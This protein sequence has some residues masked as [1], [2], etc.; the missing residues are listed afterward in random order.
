[1]GIQDKVLFDASDIA[2]QRCSF[3][4]AVIKIN[5]NLDFLSGALKPY[6]DT[7]AMVSGICETAKNQKDNYDI[8]LIDC[9]SGI[10]FTVKSLA[11]ISNASIVITTPDITAIRD[12]GRAASLIYGEKTDD[13]RL[14]VNKVKP[15]FIQKGLAPDI[16]EIIDN[17]EVRL[18][19]LIPE[20]V[21]IQIYANKGILV[22]DIKKS[23]SGKAFEN[24]AQRIS[25]N[26]VPLYKFW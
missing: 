20:D 18:L 3:E 11:K 16:D 23:I 9:P 17:T 22:S 8:I 25:G 26:N 24:I 7:E 5:E 4:K 19:G 13:V 15:K 10:G 21:K 1:M 14:I 12:A 2:A 6:N